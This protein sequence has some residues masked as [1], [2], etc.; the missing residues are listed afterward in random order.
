MSWRLCVWIFSGMFLIIIL[1]ART[2]CCTWTCVSVQRLKA[3]F[4]MNLLLVSFVHYWFWLPFSW[5][6]ILLIFRGAL[7]VCGWGIYSMCNVD[8]DCAPTFIRQTVVTAQCFVFNSW[9]SALHQISF[10]KFSFQGPGYI[11]HSALL[12]L[13]EWFGVSPHTMSVKTFPWCL[14]VGHSPAHP[15]AFPHL[16]VC[17]SCSRAWQAGSLLNTCITGVFSVKHAGDL[18]YSYP[19]CT[20]LSDCAGFSQVD[21][22]GKNHGQTML[23]LGVTVKIRWCPKDEALVYFRLVWAE[24]IGGLKSKSLECLL[25]AKNK[26]KR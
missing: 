14:V 25:E 11:F 2:V 23:K 9:P 7:L 16:S 4:S 8:Y 24:E 22:L 17:W 3:F 12:E 1:T 21:A 13:G 6:H 20:M 10:W 18:G 26:K 5:Q 15:L 19:V